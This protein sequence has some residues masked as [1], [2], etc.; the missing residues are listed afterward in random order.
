MQS[1]PSQDATIQRQRFS[2]DEI[3][4]SL[5]VLEQAI[6]NHRIWYHQLHEGLLCRQPFSDTM[7]HPLAHTLCKFG[8]WYYQNASEA[9]H[10]HP[11][12][13]AIES[14]HKTMHDAARSLIEDFV[15]SMPLAIEKYRFLANKQ[16]ELG[17]LLSNL[18]D[19]MVAQQHSFDPLTGLINRK[20]ISLILEKRHMQ[21]L[22]DA[23]PY[24]IA[25][26]D[27]DYF[28]AINDNYGHTAGDAVLKAIA[29]LLSNAFRDS[30]CVCRYGGE[31][32][33]VMLPGTTTQIAFKI[34]D[35]V[36]EEVSRL[37]VP[38]EDNLIS[39]TI[40]IGFADFDPQKPV[41]E[42]VKDADTALYQAKASGRDRVMAYTSDMD[43]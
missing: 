13:K 6:E 29:T 5:K 1:D 24:N 38:Y 4:E 14:T 23:T 2:A 10:S 30:D 8:C 33:L 40:S 26:L 43:E 41:W 12:F 32:F 16:K 20:F 31:E 22:R 27:I 21:S 39:M 36:R 42:R 34:L 37:Q 17:R 3:S 9:I 25:L 11:E 28:K 35:R 18:R 19:T 7:T 15:E